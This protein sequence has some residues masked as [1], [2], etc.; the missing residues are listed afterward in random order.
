MVEA[1]DSSLLIRAHTLLAEHP[2]PGD[3]QQA[4]RPQLL[5]TALACHGRMLE[6]ANHNRHAAAELAIA[7]A[8]LLQALQTHSTEA[9]IPDW[10]L[11]HEEQCCRYGAIWIHDLQQQGHPVSQEWV[12]RALALLHRLQQLH[13]EPVAWINQ[14]QQ[15]I[16]ESAALLPI[17]AD[18]DANAADALTPSVKRKARAPIPYA[19]LDPGADFPGD[20]PG[21]TPLLP[22]QG[23]PAPPWAPCLHT[24]R[25]G[26]RQEADAIV[27]PVGV[28]S[29]QGWRSDCVQY[30]PT[31]W[32]EAPWV[33]AQA[34]YRLEPSADG[35]VQLV[36]EQTQ[37]TELLEG[38][39]CV[40]NDIV[41]HRNLAHFF[42]DLLP[43]LVAI[44]RMRQRWPDLQVLGQTPR[45]PNLQLLRELV[46][47]GG[48]HPR[49]PAGRLQMQEL[50]LQPLAFNGGVG[51]LNRPGE[52]WWLAVEDLREGLQL[53]REALSPDPA[54]A[55]RGH[56]L[57]FSRDLVEPCEAPQGRIFSNY[58]QL[59]EQLSNAGVMVIDPGLFSSHPLQVSVSEVRGFVDIHGTGLMKGLLGPEGAR[60]GACTKATAPKCQHHKDSEGFAP[61]SRGF[62]H[63]GQ[64]HGLPQ[65][66][67]QRPPLRRLHLHFTGPLLLRLH[68][69]QSSLLLLLA[70]L[71]AGFNRL[72]QRYAVAQ[73]FGRIMA[74]Q[75]VRGDHRLPVVLL[76]CCL[77]HPLGPCAGSHYRRL[78]LA[79]LE[80]FQQNQPAA[81]PRE[82]QSARHGPATA[83]AASPAGQPSKKTG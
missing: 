65:A 69:S 52:E 72:Q 4:I 29:S 43:Q 3:C 1:A 25:L 44:R 35:T 26:W 60:S 48:W 5:S 20:H 81:L 11:E 76:E 77:G 27:L 10:V 70:L 62:P 16:A 9:P 38:R 49:P 80:V 42:A 58:P 50:L 68:K 7:G 2:D 46:L 21:G 31:Q 8:D 24:H 33:R 67:L 28:I 79:E 63:Q 23:R 32:I 39:W 73:P 36:E 19:F 71:G 17:A 6:L 54:A 15:D 22:L 40:L 75:R 55:W 37:P 74:L 64:R 66:Q 57:C 53:L 83:E 41:A 34:G 45:Y 51:F 14:L 13:P 18:A 59:L 47:P 82:R 12:K 78:R 56:W 61:T 30:L